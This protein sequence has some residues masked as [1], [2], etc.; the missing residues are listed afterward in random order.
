MPGL[1]RWTARIMCCFRAS[2]PGPGSWKKSRRFSTDRLAAGAGPLMVTHQGG[3][4]LAMAAIDTAPF[5]SSVMTV[6]PQ[7]IDYNGHLNMAY[8][9]VLFDRAVDQFFEA[10]GIGPD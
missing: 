5:I 7:W 9:N 1:S 4:S 8:Y 3:R 6:E 10:L 2:R